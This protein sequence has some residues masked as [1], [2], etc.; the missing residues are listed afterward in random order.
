MSEIFP[1][2]T[3]LVRGVLYLRAEDVVEYVTSL[4][5]CVSDGDDDTA[6]TNVHSVREATKSLMQ[7]IEGMRS[8]GK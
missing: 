8:G 7:A 6:S 4:E 1:F 5:A 2:R 3:I